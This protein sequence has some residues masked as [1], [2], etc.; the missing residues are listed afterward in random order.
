MIESGFKL[1]DRGSF[2]AGIKAVSQFSAR[3]KRE[4][5]SIDEMDISFFLSLLNSNST[6]TWNGL[7]VQSTETIGYEEQEEKCSCA[8]CIS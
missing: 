3:E 5:D 4:E 6:G 7:I 8:L 1:L 2:E